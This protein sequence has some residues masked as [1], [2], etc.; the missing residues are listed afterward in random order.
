MI[1]IFKD[2][3]RIEKMSLITLTDGGA[4]S[5]FNDKM[6]DTSN[7]L[8]AINMGYNKPVIKV[9]KKQYTIKNK[10]HYYRSSINTGL[11]LDIIKKSHGVSNIGFYV[12][13]RFKSWQMSEFT[14]K[15]LDWKQRDEWLKI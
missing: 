12:T 1:P 7:G 2:K 10:D 6:M 11:L 15:G 8:D 5:S 13:K 14:P 4:N 3:N 9:G